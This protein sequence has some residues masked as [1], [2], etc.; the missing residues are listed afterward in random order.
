M[1]IISNVPNAPKPVGPY[2]IAVKAGGLLFCSG[3]IGLDPEKGVIV[4]GG[5]EAQAKQVLDNLS[6]V[7][8]ASGSSF[9]K[10][11]M[12][13]IFLSAMSDFKSVNEIYTKYVSSDKPPARQTVAVKELPLGALI[14]ISV[15]AEG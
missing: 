12:T 8:K 15:I 3:Q 9:D 13:S 7:L 1:E 2:S 14:E 10:V 5:V 4:E 6:A 11:V